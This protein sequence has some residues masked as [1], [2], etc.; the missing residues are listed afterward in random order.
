MHCCCQYESVS[1]LFS[2]CL[3]VFRS[4]RSEMDFVIQKDGS[5]AANMGSGDGVVRLRGLPF[6]CTHDDIVNFFSG[7]FCYIHCLAMML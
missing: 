4:N 6:S 1:Y 2:M 5:G 7:N 3:P